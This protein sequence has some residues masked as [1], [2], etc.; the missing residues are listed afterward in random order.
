MTAGHFAAALA[1]KSRVPKAS[2][3]TLILAAFL[4]DFIWIIL[5]T[6][7]IEPTRRETYFDDWSHSLFSILVYALLSFCYS[8]NKGDPLLLPWELPFFRI[9]F[10]I[11]QSIQRTWRSTHTRPFIWDLV[12]PISIG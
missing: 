11:C 5:A 7:G 2:T 12:S 1:I 4:P 3:A 10:W 8:G 9:F 6:A